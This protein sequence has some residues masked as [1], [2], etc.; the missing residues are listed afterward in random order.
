MHSIDAIN[1][2]EQTVSY[3]IQ[4]KPSVIDILINMCPPHV[5]TTAINMFQ[6]E[7]ANLY[8]VAMCAL[9]YHLH[10]SLV[11]PTLTPCRTHVCTTGSGP[12]NLEE[13]EIWVCSEVKVKSGPFPV[14]STINSGTQF[15]KCPVNQ[16]E[17]RNHWKNK[18]KSDEPD[19]VLNRSAICSNNYEDAVHHEIREPSLVPY[20]ISK[21]EPKEAN[22]TTS[23]Y[24]DK[25]HN[26]DNKKHSTTPKARLPSSSRQA[27]HSGNSYEKLVNEFVSAL[28]W[29]DSAHIPIMPMY[30]SDKVVFAGS[31]DK[32]DLIIQYID[33]DTGEICKTGVELKTGLSGTDFVQCK[34]R[35]DSEM[36]KWE[37]TK[38]SRIPAEVADEFVSVLNNR[39][40]EVT[41]KPIDRDWLHPEWEQYVT[42]CRQR[43]CD[44]QSFVDPTKDVRLRLE[45][46]DFAARNYARKG[47]DY[48]QVKSL[49]LFHT[50]KDVCRLGV[51]LF[52]CSHYL[53]FRVKVHER[54]TKSTGFCRMSTMA[55]CRVDT[56]GM[57]ETSPFSLDGMDTKRGLPPQLVFTPPTW[58]CTHYS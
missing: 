17:T 41:L 45:S 11:E 9:R 21:H 32:S 36:G 44:D 57:L 1:H 56:T 25:Y 46:T 6:R 10:P 20:T 30:G 24:N 15:L 28:W 5:D 29:T 43:A 48:I 54:A 26:N 19:I 39:A 13:K 52:R 18:L 31:S 34:M 38:G 55:S 49:G 40:D 33:A 22:N 14:S 3:S 27:I 4:F 16:V 50:G 12:K 2:M 51:P 58:Y 35:W 7:R 47:C 53:R 37:P 8:T 23:R 42:Y